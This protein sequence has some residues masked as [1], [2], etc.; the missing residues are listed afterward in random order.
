MGYRVFFSGMVVLALAAAP[1]VGAD[2][3]SLSDDER[4]TRLTAPVVSGDDGEP[5]PFEEAA[6]VSVQRFEALWSDQDYGEDLTDATDEE[7]SL[8]LRAAS[9]VVVYSQVEWVVGRLDSVLAEAHTRGIADQGNYHQLFDAYLA[10]FQV[11]DA[12]Q[13]QQ[14]YPDIELPEVPEVIAPDGTPSDNGLMVWQVLSDPPGL[15]GEFIDLERA[16]LFVVNSWGCGFSRHAAKVLAD[17]E[18][19]GPMIREHSV[20]VAAPSLHNT[21]R[22]TARWNNEYPESPT[23]LVDDPDQWPFASF[24]F[25]PQFYFIRNGQVVEQVDGWRG[26]S[27][28]LRAI[29]EGFDKLGLLDISSLPED[30]FTHADQTSGAT[31]CETRTQALEQIRKQA[32]I[33]SHEQLETHLANAAETGD[34]PLLR[35]TEQARARLIDS[36]RFADKR[37]PALR[38]DDA[39]EQLDPPELYELVSLF[40]LQYFMADSLFPIELLNEAERDLLDRV[41]CSGEYAATPKVATQDAGE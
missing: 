31:P 19:L 27:Q 9:G 24:S 4:F 14:R 10:S 30:A 7:V 16:R 11:D 22:G 15:K 18:V 17:D 37:S 36:L 40:G 41:Q 1:A 8:R 3:K 39:R 35:L 28:S 12:A 5:A 13:L 21:F 26:G 20:W 32:P 29:A 23:Y 33:A 38:L 2:S 34:S 6:K 25:T